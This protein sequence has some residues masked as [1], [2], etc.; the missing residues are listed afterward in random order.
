MKPLGYGIFLCI[1]S[2]ILFGVLYMFGHWMK[3]VD[4]NNVFALRMLVMAVGIWA[5]LLASGGWASL[6]DLVRLNL[7]ANLQRWILMLLGTAIVGS[8]FWLFM[9]GA[10]NGEGVNV[11]MGYF[12]FPLAMTLA[13]KIVLGERLNVLQTAALALAALGV[14]HELFSTQAFS[15]TTLWVFALY[16]PYYLLRRQ[17]AVPA[18]AGMAFDLT[19]ILP[20]AAA[21]LLAHQEVLHLV[22]DEPRYWLLL[23]ALGLASAVSM[24]ANLK[25]SALLPMSLFGMLSYVEPALLF[26]LAV[27]VLGTPV[28]PSAYITYGLI[29][30][31]LL[32]LGVHGW[33]SWARSRRLKVAA[34]I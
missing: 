31:G 4:G 13:G 28:S 5:L 20:F 29:W 21:Y 22:A 9:W 19:V 34:D 14:G 17:M 25:S 6:R 24:S 16:P 10:V 2:Q 7:G 27:T 12:I 26:L 23:P 3:P 11:A 33:K 18:L 30:S 15:W 32:L 8:Q 1:L